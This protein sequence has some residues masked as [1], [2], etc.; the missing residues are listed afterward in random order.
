MDRRGQLISYLLG[1]AELAK[2][3][4]IGPSERGK[5]NATGAAWPSSSWSTIP[6][7]LPPPSAYFVSPLEFSSSRPCSQ[8]IPLFPRVGVTP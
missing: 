7:S 6:R 4:V 2:L 3:A 5:E 1:Y 8:F